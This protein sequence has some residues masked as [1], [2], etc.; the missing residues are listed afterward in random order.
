MVASGPRT[1][2]IDQLL[3][4][5]SDTEPGYIVYDF[6]ATRA[7]SSTL[8]KTCFMLYSPDSCTSMAKK[9][10][11]ANF[12]ESVKSKINIHKEMQIN[13]KAD[14]NEREFREAFGL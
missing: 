9:L 11:I 4:A 13:D 5:V 8:K 3:A 12:K 10:S 2:G 14:I 6:E 1:D 7:D